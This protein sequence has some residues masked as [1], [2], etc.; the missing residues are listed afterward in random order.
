M[1]HTDFPEL[2]LTLTDR[3]FQSLFL[4]IT[5]GSTL[6]FSESYRYV[7]LVFFPSSSAYVA[8]RKAESR[9]PTLTYLQPVSGA[10]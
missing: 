3:Y 2:W 6:L 7:S 10:L 9:A 1:A 4:P 5:S 8:T